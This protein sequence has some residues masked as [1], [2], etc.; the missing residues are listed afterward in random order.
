MPWATNPTC[1]IKQMLLKRPPRP[2][3]QACE[4][5]HVGIIAR[6]S[7]WARQPIGRARPYWGQIAVDLINQ[8]TAATRCDLAGGSRFL[9]VLLGICSQRQR[10]GQGGACQHHGHQVGVHVG[11]GPTILVVPSCPQHG[12]LRDADG[13]RPVLNPRSEHHD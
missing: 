2:K 6:G 12:G 9:L 7:K 1:H 5:V 3:L 8:R 13:G 10:D 4:A 11:C